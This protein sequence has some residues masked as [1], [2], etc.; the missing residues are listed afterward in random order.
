[1][2]MHEFCIILTLLVNSYTIGDTNPHFPGVARATP[3]ANMHVD[4]LQGYGSV[5]A[6][7]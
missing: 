5:F 7:M 3:Y 4:A 1:M 6:Y 2:Y